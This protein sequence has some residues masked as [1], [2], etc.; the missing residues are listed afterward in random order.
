MAFVLRLAILVLLVLYVWHRLVVRTGLHGRARIAATIA[1]LATILPMAWVMATG[2]GGAPKVT[3]AFAW[4]AFLGWAVFA[5]TFAG[6]LIVDLVTLVIWLGRR[7]L[8]RPPMDPSRRQ[9]LA[10]LTG[11]AVTV[12]VV[13]HVGYGITRV[14]ADA[15]IVDVPVTLARLP[16]ALD[17][18]TIVQLTD[19]H[20]G[21]TIGRSFIEELVDRTNAIGADMIVLTGDFVDGSVDELRAA[22][23][24]FAKLRAPHGVFF[25]TGNHEYYAGAESWIAHF[26]SLGIRVLRNERVAITRGDASFD[27]AGVD[28]YGGR[29]FLPGH[30]PDLKRALTG[31]DPARAVVLLAHQPRQVHDASQH[32]VDLQLSGHTHGGQVWPWH[33]LVSLQQGG[34]VAGRYQIGGTQLYVSRGAGYWGPPVR[35]GAPAEITRVILRSKVG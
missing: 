7:T 14:L 17:G 3:G 2:P 20:V 34:L 15:A 18:F 22:V 24:P 23:E 16:R 10:R 6:L 35:V 27:L 9:A 28:D 8:R 31:R 4:P 11:G 30:G 12:A 25:V 13:G 26:S 33:Y 21:G 19:I 32:D 29:S 5:L 1:I